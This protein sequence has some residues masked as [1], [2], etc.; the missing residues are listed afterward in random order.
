MAFTLFNDIDIALQRTKWTL[1]EVQS[2][3]AYPTT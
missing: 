3:L 1:V 2:R